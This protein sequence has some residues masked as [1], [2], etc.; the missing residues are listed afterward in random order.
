MK[1]MK[2][3]K[4]SRKNI[5]WM[6]V[7][8]F[9]IILVGVCIYYYLTIWKDKLIKGEPN[10]TAQ[11]YYKRGVDQIS[12]SNYDEAEKYLESA[13]RQQDDSS[14]RNQLAVVKYK[15]KKYQEGIDLYH[16][17]IDQGK[18]AAFSWN[19][20]GNCYRD[21][22][23]QDSSQKDNY[24]KLAEEAYRKSFEI[25]PNYIAAYSNLALM[26]SSM[27]QNETALTVINDGI[28]KTKDDNLVK[29]KS[30]LG[31]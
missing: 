29:I 31:K 19:G 7:L 18:D 17:L 21:W 4:I 6:I 27:G 11:E 26:L 15:L 30:M 2:R 16:G 12:S 22:A 28:A 5:I 24:S 9:A 10:Y 14:Y 8:V 20:I 25:D 1:H 23:E 13:L 3:G